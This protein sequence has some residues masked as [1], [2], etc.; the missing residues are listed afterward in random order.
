MRVLYF[1]NQKMDDIPCEVRFNGKTMVISYE[2]ND[3]V[4]VHVGTEEPTQ[5]HF[6]T[7]CEA[8]GGRAIVQR[9]PGSAVL[10]LYWKETNGFEGMSRIDLGKPFVK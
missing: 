8:T 1:D 6:I 2:G 7:L 4:E 10:N 5:G 9:L 3:G